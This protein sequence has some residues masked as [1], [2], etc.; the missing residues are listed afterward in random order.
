MNLIAEE[1]DFLTNLSR[2]YKREAQ[3]ES[4]ES[5]MKSMGETEGM[6]ASKEKKKAGVQQAKKGVQ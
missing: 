6:S 1:Y 3:G 5:S 4:G 2:F